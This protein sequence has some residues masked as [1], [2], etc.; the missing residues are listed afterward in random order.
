MEIQ[1]VTNI[2]IA[3]VGS[4]LGLMVLVIGYF[5][6]RLISQMDYTS[7]CVNKLTSV[8]DKLNITIES[9]QIESATRYGELQKRLDEQHMEI[10]MLRTSRHKLISYMSAMRLQGEL[11]NGWNFKTEWELPGVVPAE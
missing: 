11:K 2:L 9:I 7:Q 10:E 6:S 3:V 1:T 4:V 8:V 5:M